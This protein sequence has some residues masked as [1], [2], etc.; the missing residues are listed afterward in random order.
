MRDLQPLVR[1]NSVAVV[2]A[3]PDATII[4]GRILEHMRLHP[5]AG[6]IYPVSRSHGEVQG[7]KAYPSVA[8]L[9]EAPDLAII[10]V[11]ADVVPQTLEQCGA[12]GIKAAAIISS[13]FGEASDGDAAARDA[14]LR[15]IARRHGMA[16]SG[17]NSEGLMIADRGLAATF[18]PVVGPEGGPL[19]PESARGR[20]IAVVG[21]SGAMT[22]AFVSRGRPRQLRFAAVVSS[23]NQV[24]LEAHDYVDYWL[25]TGGPE[26]FILYIEQIVDGARFRAVADR[27]LELGRPIIV[28]RIGRSDAGRR[29]AASHTGALATSDRLDDAMFRHHGV[30]V[31]DDL[32]HITDI[33]AAVAHCPPPRGNRV[34]IITGSGGGAAWMADLLSAQ[35]LEVPELE[36]EIQA[37]I[38]PM[39]P[40]YASAK[41]PID[42]TAQAIREVGYA[43]L[44]EIVQKS[45]RVDAV[46]LIG[47]LAEEHRAVHHAKVLAPLVGRGI[48]ILFCSYTLAS[49][50]S[51]ANFAG[52]GIP[53]FTAMQNCARAL[54]ALVD[55]GVAQR[56][57]NQR[58]APPAVAPALR[59]EVDGALRAAGAA[60]TEWD[61]KAILARYGVPRPAE[62][63][64]TTA[65][66]AAAAA[67]RIGGA[68]ALKLQ[69]AAIL[70]KTEAGGVVLNVTGDAAVRAAYDTVLRNANAADPRAAIQ[71]VL[72]QAMAKPGREI[73]LGVT[74]HAGCGPMLMVGLG[75]IHVEALKDVAFAPVPLD[76]ADAQALI[77]RL[78]AAPLLG[79]VRGQPPADRAALARLMALLSRI[80]AEHADAIQ[81]IDLNPVIVH[82]QGQGLTIVDALIVT[83]G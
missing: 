56:R 43:K 42:A 54:R 75:G 60:L 70:H 30:I 31:G 21:Q 80:A 67:A 13:G 44:V 11:P 19:T 22:F 7:L 26:I 47:S 6:P 12:R 69:S 32:D 45:Q 8:D 18:S 16:L 34:A 52:S 73:I 46:V 58:A 83:R 77:D 28:A 37:E 38:A 74:R 65:D 39:L 79:A 72:V 59:G 63:L 9:P 51:V 17:P 49:P 3:S 20:P 64:A 29:A 4:R 10:V 55:Y 36:A 71:G 5:F 40:S 23:G 48:P 57:R 66:E 41:N 15:D 25:A 62:A 14:A 81:E 76:P 24:D 27:A 1:P 2:G 50:Q 35:G 61:A 78:H 82:A 33:A 53:C 68:V